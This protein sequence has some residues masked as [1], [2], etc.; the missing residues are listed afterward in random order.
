MAPGCP[1]WPVG[2]LVVCLGWAEHPAGCPEWVVLPAACPGWVARLAAC[3]GLVR[4]VLVG[5]ERLGLGR[6]REAGRAAQ[7][8]EK[9]RPEVGLADAVE[10]KVARSK[11]LDGSRKQRC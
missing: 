1:A 5:R 7:A 2:C 4:R 10:L 3:P 9:K 8:G 11:L 6:L